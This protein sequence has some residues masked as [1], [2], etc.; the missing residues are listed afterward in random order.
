MALIGNWPV[1]ADDWFKDNP[2]AWS[3]VNDGPQWLG[4]AK[5]DNWNLQGLLSNMCNYGKQ[6]WK[7]E[8]GSRVNV[9]ATLKGTH[10]VTD[11]ESLAKIFCEIAQHLGFQTAT[12]RKI[13][14]PGYRIVTRP[15]MVTFNGKTGDASLESR[16]CFGDHWV[17][18]YDNQC[19]DPTFNFK[20]LGF[21]QVPTV[22]LGWFAQ[23]MPNDKC[24][25]RTFWKA[26][27]TAPGSRDVYMRMI[28]DVAYTYKPTN[29]QG[30]EVK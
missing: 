8:P 11:C 24:F 23:E 6:N 2:V 19:F 4:T 26:D 21:A 7:Y 17:A 9:D 25:A 28:P 30:K 1:N 22:Y 14:R 12:P 18:E 15:G 10:F 16:W 20:G 27:P 29:I 5:P 3:I 13:Q